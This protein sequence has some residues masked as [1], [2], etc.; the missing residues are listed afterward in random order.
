MAGGRT[1]GGK[2]CSGEN[3]RIEEEEKALSFLFCSLKMG[4]RDY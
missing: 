2:E 4:F 3:I 1:E